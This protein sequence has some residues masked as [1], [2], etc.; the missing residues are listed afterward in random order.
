MEP[1]MQSFFINILQRT[2][3]LDVSWGSQV[4]ITLLPLSKSPWNESTNE[5]NHTLLQ[6][7]AT[8]LRTS[9]QNAVISYPW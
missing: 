2:L 4:L 7:E 9:R 8:T 6:V 1:S 3:D 5:A